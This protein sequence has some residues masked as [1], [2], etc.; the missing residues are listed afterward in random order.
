ME[1]LKQC[2]LPDQRSSGLLNGVQLQNRNRK[3]CINELQAWREAQQNA[4][5]FFEEPHTREDGKQV[6]K[7]KISVHD[8]LPGLAV[9]C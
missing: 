6:H 7:I 9:A 3:P 4:V 8:E 5:M 2:P 1:A